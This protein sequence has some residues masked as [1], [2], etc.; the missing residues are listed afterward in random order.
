MSG[1]VLLSLKKKREE[2]RAQ[3]KEK[4]KRK[5]KP[6]LGLQLLKPIKSG[7]M[8]FKS[9]LLSITFLIHAFE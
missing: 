8:V 3:K 1:S 5:E 4:E 6:R 2:K 9:G 7:T